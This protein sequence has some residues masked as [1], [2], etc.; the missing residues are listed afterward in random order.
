MNNQS[1]MVVLVYVF[2]LIIDLK[3]QIMMIDYVFAVVYDIALVG[4]EAKCNYYV[5]YQV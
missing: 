5:K 4:G 3:K 2:E 1:T